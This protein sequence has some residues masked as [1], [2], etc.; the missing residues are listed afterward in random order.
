MEAA[1]T[2]TERLLILGRP[3]TWMWTVGQACPQLHLPF[4]LAPHAAGI[5]EAGNAAV[6]MRRNTTTIHEHL[7]K[8]GDPGDQGRLTP[9]RCSPTVT[10]KCTPSL[11]IIRYATTLLSLLLA[12]VT[13]L[14]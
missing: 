1:A 4:C 7:V 14:L 3:S 11:A 12:R 2:S 10:T 13:F 9:S 5:Q 6:C 8:A